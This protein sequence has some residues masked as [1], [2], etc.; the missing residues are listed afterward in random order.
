MPLLLNLLATSGATAADEP[1]TVA[2]LVFDGVELLDFAGPAEVFIVASQRRPFR[3]VTVAPTNE[4]IRTMGGIKIKPDFVFGDVP[5]AD[6]L[7]IPVAILEASARG[8][9]LGSQVG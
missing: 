2:V 4:L 1:I 3:V 8:R 5:A 7:V 6:V 9:R